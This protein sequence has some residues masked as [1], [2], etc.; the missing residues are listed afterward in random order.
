MPGFVVNGLGQGA[1]STVK[2]YYKYTWEVQQFYG[3]GIG[4]NPAAENLPLIYLREAS[5]PSCDFD[6]E[7]VQGANL[8]YKFAKSIKWNDIKFVWYDTVGMATKIREWRRN[9]WTAEDGL[10]D[11]DVYK[12][13]S[14]LRSLDFSWANPIVWNCF[15][16]WPGSIK[17]G[18]LTYTDSDIKMVEVVLVYDWAD[19]SMD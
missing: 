19:D 10:A 11:P 2:P 15:N 18:D 1:P 5:L 3:D 12:R 14:T 13:T 9:V 7:E 6:K 4:A 16:S 8:V 17:V